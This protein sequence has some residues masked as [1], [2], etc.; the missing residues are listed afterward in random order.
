MPSEFLFPAICVHIRNTSIMF[1]EFLALTLFTPISQALL[2]AQHRV[3]SVHSRRTWGN[4]HTIFALLINV[5]KLDVDLTNTVTGNKSSLSHSFQLFIYWMVSYI[6]TSV[7]I[8]GAEASLYL[9][10]FHRK[11]HL[12]A[13]KSMR[14]LR[15]WARR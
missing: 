13:S 7:K 9:T 3:Q 4:I 10:E 1:A 8:R 2:V 14:D 12:T 6:C 15:Q 11:Q 5:S